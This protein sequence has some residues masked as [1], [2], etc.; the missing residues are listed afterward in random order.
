MLYPVESETREVKDLS[1]IWRFK[2][3]RN[4]EGYRNKWYETPLRDTIMM[5]VPAS[6]NDITQ[7]ATIRDHIG[8]VWYERTF[9]VPASWADKR[10][11]IRVGSATHSAVMWVNGVEVAAHK[12]GYLPFEADIS[13]VVHVGV[14]NRVTIAVNNILDNTTI[15]IGKIKRY[16]DVFHPPGYKVQEIYHDFFNYAGIHRPVKLYT[17]PKVFIEDITLVTDIDGMDGL[18]HYNIAVAGPTSPE[19]IRVRVADEAGNIVATGSQLKGTCRIEK[20][21]L[22]EPGNAYLYTF[23]VELVTKEEEIKDCYRLPVGVRT[24]HV[25]NKKF[26]INGK[27]FYFKGFGKH[28]DMDIRGKGLDDAINVKDFNLLKWIGAN[29]FRTSHYPYSEEILQMADREGIVVIAESPAVGF[30]FWNDK[31]VFTDEHVHPEALA[32]HLNVME[33]MIKRDKNHP[34]IVMWSVANEATTHEDG[35]FSYFKAVADKTRSL[36]PTRP[37]TIVQNTNP[38]DCKVAQLFDVICVNRYPSWYTDSG[39]LEVIERQLEIELTKWHTRFN[40]PVMMTEYGADTIA[41]FHSDPPV[42]FSEEYQCALLEHHH[43]VFDR[44]DFIIGEHV[45]NFADFAT[46]QGVTRVGGNKKGVFTRQRQPKAAA[47]LLRKRWH[48][49]RR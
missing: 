8:D 20:V 28:E 37:I 12:G 45:W 16:D 13:D 27:P 36:D 34:S 3:D 22:W 11:M 15:P 31:E 41:G 49:E 5:P 19:Q 32:H 2:I 23:L 7:D 33:E 44:L 48:T 38:D 14:E 29:S 4:H 18:I 10:I 24:V 42:M 26:L 39:H 1:G 21:Q 47:H 30:N 25:T 17:T 46:K 40:Q 9:F 35:A 43:R 6:Y